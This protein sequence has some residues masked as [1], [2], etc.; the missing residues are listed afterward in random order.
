M[1]LVGIKLTNLQLLDQRLL[2]DPDE[3]CY[4]FNTTQIFLYSKLMAVLFTITHNYTL[5]RSYIW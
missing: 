4:I 3:N 5:L 1:A 2:I